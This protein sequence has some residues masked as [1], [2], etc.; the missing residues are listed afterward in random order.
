MC[1]SILE[2]FEYMLREHAHHWNKEQEK[3]CAHHMTVHT[4]VTSDIHVCICVCVCMDVCMHVYSYVC[5]CMY[6]HTCIHVYRTYV[7]CFTSPWVSPFMKQN[8]N[9]TKFMKSFTA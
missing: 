1:A 8:F 3:S 6:I 9:R 7:W 5:T 2:D 4:S